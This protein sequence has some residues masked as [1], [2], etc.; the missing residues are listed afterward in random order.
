MTRDEIEAEFEMAGSAYE[1]G[2]TYGED[3]HDWVAAVRSI[4][5]EL[6]R[7]LT[8]RERVQFGRGWLAGE[9][10]RAAWLDAVKRIDAEAA[11]MRAAEGRR[12][13]EPVPVCGDD[14]I[15]F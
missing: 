2:R 3:G 5:A 6:G 4:R 10:D 7:D 9:R 11:D 14:E 1:I 15:P 12:A 8:A 13:L